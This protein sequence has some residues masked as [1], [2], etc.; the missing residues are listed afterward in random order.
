MDWDSTQM[1]FTVGVRANYWDFNNQFFASPRAT[2]AA[3]PNW[4]KDFL[5]RFSLGSYYQPPFFKE[6]RS[7][8]GSLNTNIKAQE[9][10]HVVLASDYNFHLWQRPFKFVSE[11]YYKYLNNLIPYTVENVMIRY[12]PEQTA[13]GYSTGIDFR[14][15]GEF[16]PGIDSWA[17][18]SF[19]KSEEDILGD[20]HGF[21][22]RPTDQRFNA[23]I[24]FQDYLPKFPNFKVHLT[25]FYGTGMPF[26]PPNSPRYMQTARIPDYFRTDIGFT[27]ILKDS[28]SKS[29]ERSLFKHFKA[30]LLTAEIFNMM[31]KNNTISYV[32]VTDIQNRQYAVPNYLTGLRF[33]LK[34]TFKF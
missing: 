8:D 24:F 14:I 19:M 11:L 27:A 28:K 20:G 2:L 12:Y 26:G 32:W 4:E 29:S 22:P 23:S 16:V 31:N 6:Y 21:I 25:L 9:S 33:N 5:F 10:Y 17:S 7:L 15:F 30:V 3:K 34:L 1:F 18:V 13:V